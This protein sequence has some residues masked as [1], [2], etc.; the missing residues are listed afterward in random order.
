MNV[1]S[2]A[3]MTL[4]VRFPG[5]GHNPFWCNPKQ[6]FPQKTLCTKN[7]LP[8]APT[9]PELDGFQQNKTELANWRTAVANWRRDYAAVLNEWYSRASKS[10]AAW[11]AGWNDN[12][13]IRR[14]A[15]VRSQDLP[16]F[17]NWGSNQG[18]QTDPEHL[19]QD[20]SNYYNNEG[21]LIKGLPDQTP[22]RSVLPGIVTEVLVMSE[23]EFYQS[24]VTVAHGQTLGGQPVMHFSSY[25]HIEP[26]AYP[27]QIVAEGESIG[28]INTAGYEY[29]F[30]LAWEDE[31]MLANWPQHLHF[32]LSTR[33]LTGNLGIYNND[34][35]KTLT[36]ID[37][38]L[39]LA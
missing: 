29:G 32:E 28:R 39:Y 34:G 20:L 37:P 35:E 11:P 13:F 33:Q 30:R 31:K 24:T 22:I 4:T 12:N 1:S 18:F 9:Y 15:P 23:N 21:R 38:A 26:L 6:P 19:G 25:S 7:N 8:A 14:L 27:G 10:L 36:R 2:A 16:A 3:K 17:R 5:F